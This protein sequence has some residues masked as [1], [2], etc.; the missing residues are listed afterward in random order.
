MCT[1]I[2]W[3]EVDVWWFPLDGFDTRWIP[4]IFSRGRGPIVWRDAIWYSGCDVILFIFNKSSSSNQTLKLEAPG[5]KF[6]LKLTSQ[7]NLV[8]RLR[9]KFMRGTWPWLIIDRKAMT[10][11]YASQ[12]QL[13]STDIFKH[14]TCLM[15]CRYKTQKGLVGRPPSKYPCVCVG[16]MG[17]WRQKKINLATKS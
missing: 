3:A 15:I 12:N 5:F 7:N 8:E 6:N 10:H 16:R 1:T 13:E 2:E 4:R 9:R 17:L 14:V 11:L